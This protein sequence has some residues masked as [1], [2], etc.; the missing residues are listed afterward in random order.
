MVKRGSSSAARRLAGVG[1]YPSKDIRRPN[2][3][4]PFSG[5][6]AGALFLFGHAT[7]AP[8]GQPLNGM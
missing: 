2:H 5:R 4:S 8:A 6:P 3:A 7:G 1:R